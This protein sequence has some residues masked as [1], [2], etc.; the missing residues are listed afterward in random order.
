M[1]EWYYPNL[2][3]SIVNAVSKTV[4]GFGSGVVD[5][6][7]RREVPVEWNWSKHIGKEKANDVNSYISTEI[8]YVVSDNKDPKD[9]TAWNDFINI[10]NFIRREEFMKVCQSGYDWQQGK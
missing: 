9:D 1:L 5:I 4:K 3:L 8:I 7:I 10:M 6:N 2:G